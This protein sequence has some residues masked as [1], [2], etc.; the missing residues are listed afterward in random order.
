ML[1]EPIVLYETVCETSSLKFDMKPASNHKSNEWYPTFSAG[2]HVNVN[3]LALDMR[4]TWS[5]FSDIV[6]S[7]IEPV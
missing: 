6:S 7:V 2:L 5:Q 3:F 1:S 4:V